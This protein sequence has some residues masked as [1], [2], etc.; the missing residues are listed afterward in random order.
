M[1][2][3]IFAILLT[4]VYSLEEIMDFFGGLLTQRR[5]TYYKQDEGVGTTLLFFAIPVGLIYFLNS[6]QSLTVKLAWL[7]AQM[8]LVGILASGAKIFYRRLSYSQTYSGWEKVGLVGFAVMGLITPTVRL[9]NHRARDLGE[10]TTKFAFWLSLPALAA[11]LIAYFVPQQF[12]SDGL[13]NLDSL[14]IVMF[15]G[16]VILVT[17]E[18]LERFLRANNFELA[19][20]FRIALGVVII[21]LIASGLV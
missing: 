11:L 5:K 20:Y 13:P 18:A 12:G 3:L 19:T 6:P 4:V 16:L 7:S 2:F 9:I 8:I 1:K 10:I 21:Y 14:T 17:I 15:G